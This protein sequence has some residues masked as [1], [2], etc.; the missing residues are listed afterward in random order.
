VGLGPRWAGVGVAPWGPRP[1][2]VSESLADPWP[3][4]RLLPSAP[5]YEI[6][7]A[8]HVILQVSVGGHFPV[9]LPC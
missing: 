7:F 6:R 3:E 5:P 9:T 2:G 4:R 1:L 8:A